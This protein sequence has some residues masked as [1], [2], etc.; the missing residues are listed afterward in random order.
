MNDIISKDNNSF[1]DFLNSKNEEIIYPDNNRS[2]VIIES[3][4][5]KAITHG[6]LNLESIFNDML[7]I[8]ANIFYDIAVKGIQCGEFNIEY[9]ESFEDEVILLSDDISQWYFKEDELCILEN[10]LYEIVSKYQIGLFI[11]RV[12]IIEY[13]TFI[14]RFSYE[15]H[16][17]EDCITNDLSCIECC[18]AQQIMFEDLN[19]PMSSYFYGGRTI[20]M[21]DTDNQNNQYQT[22]LLEG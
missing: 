15:N 5:K 16:L 4:I 9:N 3:I 1:L 2:G 6:D 22:N 19:P 17:L 10:M 7:C 18:P 21:F 12:N 14:R 13:P 20:L 8:N 11:N